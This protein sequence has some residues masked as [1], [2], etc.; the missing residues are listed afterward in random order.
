MW[1][2]FL[3]ICI[4]YSFIFIYFSYT[5]QNLYH[6]QQNPIL[7]PEETMKLTNEYLKKVQIELFYDQ[8]NALR[9]EEEELNEH[10]QI[11]RNLACS[12][13]EY[14]DIPTSS[15]GRKGLRTIRYYK[16]KMELLSKNFDKQLEYISYKKYALIKAYI[17]IITVNNYSRE[18][19]EYW[20][21]TRELQ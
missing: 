11:A 10:F 20:E 8:L 1:T 6:I 21:N 12:E 14:G 2:L 17:P 18:L 5:L 16:E 15:G 4:Y 3:V 19:M 7:Y 13:W 9:A